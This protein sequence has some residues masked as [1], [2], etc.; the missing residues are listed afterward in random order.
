MY[1]PTFPTF[2]LSATIYRVCSPYICVFVPPC[3]TISHSISALVCGLATPSTQNSMPLKVLNSLR[4]WRVSVSLKCAT[5]SPLRFFFTAVPLRLSFIEPV[6][7]PLLSCVMTFASTSRY[8]P[9]SYWSIV[10]CSW[11]Y[12][13]HS[14][15]FLSWRM[16]WHR[17]KRSVRPMLNLSLGTMQKYFTSRMMELWASIH[18]SGRSPVRAPR[19]EPPG[20]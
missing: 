19:E 17:G 18:T 2:G 10:V 7:R 20:R 13:Q 8:L 15:Q 5:T 14:F 9:G 16:F 3:R 12:V 6:P 4:T 11:S 1:R